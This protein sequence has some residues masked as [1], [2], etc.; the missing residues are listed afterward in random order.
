[1]DVAEAIRTKRAVR[2][3]T[4]QPVAEDAIRAVLNAGRRAQSSKNSQPWHFIAIRDRDTLR[5][6]SECGEY[7]GHL[8]RLAK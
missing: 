7:A 8:E 5:R 2:R 6:L 3:F 4:D 1:M